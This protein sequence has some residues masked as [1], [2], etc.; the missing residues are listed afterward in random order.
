MTNLALKD[1]R[2]K[3]LISKFFRKTYYF[4]FMIQDEADNI[5]RLGK[6]P[7]AMGRELPD[8]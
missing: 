3:A 5:P 8:N 2:S 6:R 4:S 1:Q 7:K